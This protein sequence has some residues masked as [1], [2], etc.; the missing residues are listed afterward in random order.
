[1]KNFKRQLIIVFAFALFA[2]MLFA[3]VN[4][5]AKTKTT[6]YQY[7]KK[8]GV[9]N[10]TAM[11]VAINRRYESTDVYLTKSGDYVASVKT[12]SPNLIAKVTT[13]NTTKRTYSINLSDDILLNYYNR[14]EITFLARSKGTYTATVTIKDKNGKKKCTKKIRVYA[15]NDSYPFVSVSYGKQYLVC[16]TANTTSKKSGKLSVKINPT[17]KL[18]SVDVCK[19]TD[20][21]TLKVFKKKANNK[22]LKLNM[23]TKYQFSYKWSESDTSENIVDVNY[24]NPVTPVR[25]VVYDTLLKT[26]VT[27]NF[28][29]VYVK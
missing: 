6:T 26:T 18:K 25:V 23:S 12:S 2:G 8:N 29:L 1:M 4:A 7:D 13:V 9:C 3:P 10:K 24:M 28:Y 21:E 5:Q 14:S 20:N 15:T 27:Y 16:G 11:R 17:F 19:F 22:I